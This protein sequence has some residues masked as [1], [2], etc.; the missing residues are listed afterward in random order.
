MMGARKRSKNDPEKLPA[1]ALQEEFQ[2][3]FVRHRATVFASVLPVFAT[4]AHPKYG[5][6][7]R[8]KFV[9]DIAQAPR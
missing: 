5:A 9:F 7:L 1:A 6:V 4:N 8:T 2:I 3:F